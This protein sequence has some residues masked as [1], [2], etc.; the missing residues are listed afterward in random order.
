[1]AVT[2]SIAERRLTTLEVRKTPTRKHVRVPQNQTTISPD[3][4]VSFSGQ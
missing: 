3:L 4:G 2:Q 1:M